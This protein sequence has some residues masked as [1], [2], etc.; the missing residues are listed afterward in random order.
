MEKNSVSLCFYLYLLQIILA[1][2]GYAIWDANNNVTRSATT[3]RRDTRSLLFAAVY[4][5]SY[6]PLDCLTAQNR[7]GRWSRS[8]KHEAAVI[9]GAL[10]KRA[11]C[12]STSLLSLLNDK[13]LPSYYLSIGL[14]DINRW[15]V[16]SVIHIWFMIKCRLP[17]WS[18]ASE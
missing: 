5:T 2:Q 13:A 14:L 12:S 15:R 3:Q 11:I 7:P 16:T 8:A 6:M 10:F 4:R 18:C 9:H 17:I 1:S